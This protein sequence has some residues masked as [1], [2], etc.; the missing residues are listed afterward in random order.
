MCDLPA[1]NLVIPTLFCALVLLAAAMPGHGEARA[2]QIGTRHLDD[3]TA[4]I[5]YDYPAGWAF[6][7][8]NRMPMSEAFVHSVATDQE[9]TLGCGVY[10]VDIEKLGLSMPLRLNMYVALR[11]AEIIG[12]EPRTVLDQ[13]VLVLDFKSPDLARGVTS[14]M[15]GR[16]AEVV[17]GNHMVT[18]ICG[19]PSDLETRGRDA[20]SAF[21]LIVETIKPR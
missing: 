16:M 13:E 7:T 10:A 21:D 6:D 12:V 9:L 1:E 4:P 11:D 8:N 2:E 15:T 5:A 20:F 17:V 3:P 19:Q 14:E 18:I